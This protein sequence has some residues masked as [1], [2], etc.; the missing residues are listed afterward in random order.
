MSRDNLP[1]PSWPALSSP[2]PAQ[3]HLPLRLRDCTERKIGY[4]ATGGTVAYWLTIRSQCGWSRG[5]EQVCEKC[6]LLL[7]TR[8]PVTPAAYGRHPQAVNSGLSVVGP[9]CVCASRRLRQ[10]SCTTQAGC[11]ACQYP[12]WI[13][14]IPGV[15][16]VWAF[17]LPRLEAAIT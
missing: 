9:V 2:C 15:S 8:V 3:G 14:P 10:A 6:W 12:T 7:I 4:L 11:G 5:G 17:A 1:S 16:R 13:L